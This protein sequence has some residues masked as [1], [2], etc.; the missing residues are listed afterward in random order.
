MS[1]VFSETKVSSPVSTTS[2]FSTATLPSTTYVNGVSPNPPSSEDALS[3]KSSP[4]Q[5]LLLPP[6]ENPEP[7][8]LTKAPTHQL[9]SIHHTL[10]EEE[11]DAENRRGRLEERPGELIA[12]GEC[13]KMYPISKHMI[14]IPT[15][16][17]SKNCPSPPSVIGGLCRLTGWN[18]AAQTKCGCRKKREKWW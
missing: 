9:L 10:F 16:S 1:H 6:M 5:I 2:A 17:F 18:S 8:L 13:W 3:P 15:I 11:E 12:A 7:P 4:A 14:T